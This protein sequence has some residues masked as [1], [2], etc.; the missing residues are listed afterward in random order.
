MI[1]TDASVVIT[2]LVDETQA[3]Y[4]ARA[5][6]VDERLRAPE[7]LDLEVA[8]AL[9][10]RAAAGALTLELAKEAIRDLQRLPI[11]RIS[12]RQLLN[13]C[14]ELRENVTIYDASYVALAETLGAV[15]VTADKRLARAPGL[16]CAVEVLS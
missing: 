7:L 8:S 15:L 10:R 9:R 6:L 16:R 4:T 1:V 2:A 14:W 5:R 11:E 12:H 13:R 3:G